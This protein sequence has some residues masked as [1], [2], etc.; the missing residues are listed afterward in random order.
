MKKQNKKYYNINRNQHLQDIEPFKSKGIPTDIILFKI[1]PGCG[2]TTSEIEFHRHSIIL[3]PNVPVIVGKCKKYKEKVF[4]IYEGITI[5]K[6]VEY[7]LNEIEHKKMIVTPES[8]FK[9]KEAIEQTDF[10]LYTDFFLLFDECEKIIQDVDYR[11][12]I[13]LPMDDFFQF[14]NKAFVSATPLYPSDPRFNQNGFTIAELKPT[15]K[16]SQPLKLLTTNNIFLTLE[17]FIKDNP[18]DK[19]FIFFNTTDNIAD[20]IKKLKIEEE[21]KV[22]CAKKSHRKLQL[23][24]YKYSSTELTTF[25]KFNFFTCRFYSAVDIDYEM[26]KCEPTIIMI[27]DLVFAGHS[28]ID[29]FTEAIQIVG[30]FRKPKDKNLK[31]EIIHITNIDENLSSMTRAESI[32]YLRECHIVYKAVDRYFQSAT[33]LASKETL[34]QMLTKIDYAKYIKLPQKTRNWDMVDNLI[35]DETVKGYYK[36]Q[37]NLIEA[38]TSSKHFDLV[39]QRDEIYT[40]TDKDRLRARPKSLPLKSLHKIVSD[41]LLK[42]YKKLHNNKITEFEY[43]IEISNLQ[44][45]FP[46]EMAPINKYGLDNAYKLDF[47]IK[48]VKQQILNDKLHNDMFGMMTFIHANFNVGG[49]YTSDEISNTLKRGFKVNKIYGI[50]ASVK[51]LRKFAELSK[52]TQRVYMGVTPDGKEIRGYKLFWF[53]DKGMLA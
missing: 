14:T 32:N 49:E 15:F 28:K 34:R 35:F 47:D 24:K 44:L 23:N 18:R 8:F 6:I 39:E 42:L 33:T 46:D 1:L 9:V 16:Y 38:Y 10:N 50:S 5:D 7:L 43:S 51:Y 31:R 2:A 29:P 52:P 12:D 21:S 25:K 30:R 20:L 17:K 53:H 40:W 13:S 41:T 45:D 37:L 26:F 11:K 48:A 4:G 3:E 19:Y 36:N 22:F 27:S